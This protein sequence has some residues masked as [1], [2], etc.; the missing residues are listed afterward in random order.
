MSIETVI[1]AQKSL[2]RV[3]RFDVSSLPRVA[4]LGEAYGFQAALTPATRTI[5]LF[6]KLPPDFLSELP[7][8]Q[9]NQIKSSADAFHNVLESIL[10]FDSKQENAVA[11]HSNILRSINE[12]YQSVF[13]QIHSSIS[14]LTSRQ[15]D[16]ASQEQAFRAA[17][18]GAKD[19]AE[20]LQSV[21][22]VHQEQA[23]RILAEIRKGAAEQGVSQQA[24]YFAN[25]STAH[26][27]QANS[28]QNATIAAAGVL[29]IYAALSALAHK[30]GWLSPTNAYE[31]VQL[32]MSKLLIFIVL[33]YIL[34]LS[35]RN[36]LAHKHNS[37]VNK[38]RQNAL[39]TFNA[40]ADAAG[41]QE[42]RDIVLTHA[43]AC[44]FSPQDTGY[45]RSGAPTSNDGSLGIVQAL[46]RLATSSSST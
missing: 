4:Q 19:K 34:V 7:D 39:L 5:E 16:I 1:E 45:G 28:W 27:T 43:S 23:E 30:W 21:L 32:A 13:G 36:F 29:V 6:K 20:E 10:S 22:S 24:S 8:K 35:A 17:I 46:P 11:A 44:I 38:H 26:D 31:T 33:A 42:N 37:I 12:Q 15:Y 18:Q 9:L 3:Q 2:D 41:S 14:Y 40:L 25:E